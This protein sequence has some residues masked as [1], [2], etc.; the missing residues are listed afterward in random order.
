MSHRPPGGGG[1]PPGRPATG[2][3]FGFGIPAGVPSASQG[4]N[5]MRTQLMISTQNTGMEIPTNGFG[6]GVPQS[7][8]ANAQVNAQLVGGGQHQQTNNRYN[9]QQQEPRPGQFYNPQATVSQHQPQDLMNHQQQNRIPA[10]P[11]RDVL[12]QQ[13]RQHQ[14]HQSSMIQQ[15]QQHALPQGFTPA[16]AQQSAV[17]GQGFAHPQSV[18]ISA[19]SSASAHAYQR[20]PNFMASQFGS[21]S[22][23]VPCGFGNHT[24]GVQQA[25]SVKQDIAASNIPAGADSQH[26]G[27]HLSTSVSHPHGAHQSHQAQLQRSS[28]GGHQQQHDQQNVALPS[29]SGLGMNPSQQH[30]GGFPAVEPGIGAPGVPGSQG[31][32]SSGPPVGE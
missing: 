4:F 31:Q 7:S 21:S 9:N 22:N 28:T 11:Q 24:M 10:I 29:A 3:G 16:S 5:M 17:L 15:Q 26:S 18:A 19:S 8:I 20:Q 30:M 23:V 6:G 1:Q 25:G 13:P 12:N 14:S 2:S 27:M 32:A